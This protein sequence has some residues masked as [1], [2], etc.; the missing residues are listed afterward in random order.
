[1]V[2]EDKAPAPQREQGEVVLAV[3][4]VCARALGQDGV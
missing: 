4:T 3:G 2:T 1:M